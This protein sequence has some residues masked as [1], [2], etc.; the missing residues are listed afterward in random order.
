VTAAIETS[1]LRS[2]RLQLLSQHPTG[3]GY[4]GD[5]E[6]DEMTLFGKEHVQRYRATGGEDGYE[7]KKGTTILL[8]TTTGRK[9]GNPYT[10]PLIFREH[11][12]EYVV[13]ASKGGAAEAPDWFKNLEADPNVEVQ[14]KDRVF[15]ARARVAD[16]D[17]KATLWPLMVEV[18]PDYAEYQKKTDRQIPVVVLEAA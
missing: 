16:P 5:R 7:W 6:R 11:D 17:E 18:W 12:G 9:S 2:L 10:A 1:L 13:V 15:A 4:S 8:L 3:E 14:V